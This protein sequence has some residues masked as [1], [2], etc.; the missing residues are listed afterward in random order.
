MLST[1]TRRWRLTAALFAGSTTVGLSSCQRQPVQCTADSAQTPVVDII[2]E[3]LEASIAKDMRGANN[4]RVA[5]LSKIRAAIAQL[6]ISIEDI[7]TSK[8][9]PNSTKR[10]CAGTLRVRFPS[11]TLADADKARSAA[12]LN[13]VSDLADNSDVERHAESFTTSIEFNVQ[14]TDDGSKVFAETESGNNLFRFA[15]ELLASALMRG[16][17]E[18]SQREAQQA[19]QQQSAEQD[20][21]ASEQRNANLA[22]ART[23]NQ[24]ATQTVAAVWRAIPGDTRTRLLP[25]QRAWIRKKNADCAVEAASASTDATEREAARLVCDTRLTQERINALSEFRGEEPPTTEA[26]DPQDATMMG[27]DVE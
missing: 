3:Q 25:L 11:D 19:A 12:G 22:S 17:V 10:F 20:A 2:K 13:S 9:D 27:N 1:R 7:R 15:T 14:P 8:V 21:A 23:E 18:D 6:A 4:G 5:S 24:L 16:A 26:S